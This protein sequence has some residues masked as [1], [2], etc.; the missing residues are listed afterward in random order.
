MRTSGSQS[1]FPQN[2]IAENCGTSW[3]VTANSGEIE[4][5]NCNNKSLSKIKQTQRYQFSVSQKYG[6]LK[7]S[8]STLVTSK[9]LGIILFVTPSVWI[10]SIWFKMPWKKIYPHCSKYAH[11]NRLT[12]G[13]FILNFIRASRFRQ[14]RNTWLVSSRKGSSKMLSILVQRINNRQKSLIFW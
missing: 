10:S 9:P 1:W 2:Y 11:K 12:F 14:A 4:R 13:I 3:E 8:T 6:V 5:T 7:F